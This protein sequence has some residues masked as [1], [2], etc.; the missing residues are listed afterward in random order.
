MNGFDNRFFMYMEDVDICRR[1][2]QLGKKKLFYPKVEIIHTH[3]KDSS[4]SIKLFI[5]HIS[6]IIKYFMKWGFNKALN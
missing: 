3:R 6:S 5:I 4:K 2:D 1:I